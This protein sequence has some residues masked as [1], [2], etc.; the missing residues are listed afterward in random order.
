MATYFEKYF[1][2]GGEFKNI[3]L[4]LERIEKALGESDFSEKNLGKIIHVA[5]T[6]GKGS[7]CYFLDQILRQ[8]NFKT[9]LF[10]SPHIV[11]I[12]ERI[13]LN[14]KKISQKVFDKS[15]CKLKKIIENNHLTYFE[16]ITLIAFNIF[17]DFKPD[18]SIIETGLGGKFDATNAL[19]NKIPVITTISQDHTKFLGN[20]IYNI[21]EEKLGIVKDNDRFY[22]GK[23]RNFVIDYIKNSTKNKNII[24]SCKAEPANKFMKP[25]SYNLSLAVKIAECEFKTEKIDFSKL[26]LPPC[27]FEKIDRFIL[28]GAH[29]PSGL[30]TLMKNI[31]NVKTAIISCTDDRDILKSIKIISEKIKQ[32][33]VTEIPDNNR[34]IKLENINFNNTIIPIKKPSEALCKALEI[35]GNHDILVCGSLYLCSYVRKILKGRKY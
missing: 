22:I 27:R 19:N 4:T 1:H 14:G 3:E 9:V 33:I 28:D 13:K 20:S 5:G 18:V 17:Q 10:T 26:K 2:P 23:N 11:N 34:S 25:F 35:D 12:T 29:N 6:N 7:T 16:A 32:I 8:N 30:I 15:F 24:T 31:V 21:I